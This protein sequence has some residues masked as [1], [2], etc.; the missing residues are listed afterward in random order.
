MR[1]HRSNGL[2]EWFEHTRS[3]TDDESRQHD[4]VFPVGGQQLR[5]QVHSVT[6]EHESE[7]H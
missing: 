7:S 1:T 4:H 6:S 3:D 2:N 5:A